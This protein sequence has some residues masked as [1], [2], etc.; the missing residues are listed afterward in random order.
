MIIHKITGH[1]I[2]YNLNLLLQIVKKMNFTNFITINLFGKTIFYC[3][4]IIGNSIVLRTFCVFQ[5]NLN[6]PQLK[7]MDSCAAS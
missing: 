6:N 2:N 1:L 7:N 3:L 4:C 5:I